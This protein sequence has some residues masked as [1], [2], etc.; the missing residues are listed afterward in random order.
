MTD[1]IKGFTVVLDKDIR[2][3]DFE[4]YFQSISLMKG[5]QQVIPHEAGHEDAIADMRAKNEIRNK[6]YDFI[7]KL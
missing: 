1:R 5:V 7:A 2:E 6:L 3:D 4:V